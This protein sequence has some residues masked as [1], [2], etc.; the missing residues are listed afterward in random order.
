MRTVEG[1]N[2]ST[3]DDVVSSTSRNQQLVWMQIDV[4]GGAATE[5]DK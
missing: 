1:R 2:N 5:S 3:R 4:T